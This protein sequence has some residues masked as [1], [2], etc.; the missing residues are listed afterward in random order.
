MIKAIF[1]DIDGTL[2]SLKS[3]RAS[4]STCRAL[5]KA[6]Q[7]G[8]K[9]FIATGRNL[10]NEGQVLSLLPEFDG[11]CAVNGQVCNLFDGTSV[12]KRVIDP[13]DVATVLRLS[14]E[15]PFGCNFV[16]FD[17][18]YTG[19]VCERAKVF[20]AGMGNTPLPLENAD[21]ALTHAVYSVTLYLY[22]NEEYLIKP[23]LKHS[24]LTRWHPMIADIV[25]FGGGKHAGIDAMIAYFGIDLA[26]TMAVGDGGNDV[27]MIRHAGV[28]VAMG[29]ASDDI[30]S[31]ADYVAGNCDEDGIEKLL[32]HFRVI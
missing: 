16:E 13:E 27:S 3:H 14:R 8:V 32:Q 22:E 31:V 4:E 15:V 6:R 23:Y 28:G 11:Y 10:V 17:R 26:E 24:E 19:E 18:A 25:P 20:H 30:K 2:V 5:V 21:R 9:I 29:N 1:F 12:Y 7:N